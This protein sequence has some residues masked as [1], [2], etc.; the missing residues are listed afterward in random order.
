MAFPLKTSHRVSEKLEI[1]ILHIRQGL[2]PAV[3]ELTWE[4]SSDDT[5]ICTTQMNTV[6]SSE[7]IK[8]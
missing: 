8:I 2:T 5:D 3:L 4:A 1:Y 6:F 7:T